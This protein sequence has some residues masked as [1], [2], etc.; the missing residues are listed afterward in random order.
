MPARSTAARPKFEIIENFDHPLLPRYAAFMAENA[1]HVA[2]IEF[3]TDR[4][5]RAWTYDVNTN[6]NYNPDA[7]RAAGL[8]GMRALAAYLGEE[9]ARAHGVAA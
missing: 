9:L 6:T 5:G 4:L 8:Y 3:I 2:G 7:E 1:I